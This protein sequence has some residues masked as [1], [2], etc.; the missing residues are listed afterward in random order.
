MAAA[1][2]TAERVAGGDMLFASGRLRLILPSDW[3]AAPDA[4]GVLVANGDLSETDP[5]RSANGLGPVQVYMRLDVIALVGSLSVE[6]VESA[7]VNQTRLDLRAAQLLEGPYHFQVSTW[8]GHAYVSPVQ[9]VGRDDR[10]LTAFLNLG[11]GDLLIARILPYDGPGYI[12]AL[13]VLATLVRNP[14][15]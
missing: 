2:P 13:S 7:W 8:V 10:V 12:D 4:N 14:G 15:P 9:A 1:T 11:D 5:F 3:Q 6:S